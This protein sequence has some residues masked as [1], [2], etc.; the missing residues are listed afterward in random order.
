[1]RRAT[2]VVLGIGCLTCVDSAARA[3]APVIGG[4]DVPAGEWREVAAIEDNTN[5][6]FCTGTLIAPTVVLT[7]AHC[8]GTDVNKVV[9][10]TNSLARPQD[11]ETI[12]VKSATEYPG[13]IDTFDLGVVVLQTPSTITPRAIAAGWAS[14]AIKTG[15]TATVAGY[16][17]VDRDSMVFKD[18]M[19]EVD[20]PITDEDCTHSDG[21]NA[22]AKPAGELGAGGNGLDTCEGD[23][24]GPMFITGDLG[25]FLGGVTS[26][27]Y[28]SNQYTCSEGGIY[29]RPDK[30]IKWIED[31]AGVE[32]MKG[33]MPTWAD[34]HSPRGGAADTMVDANDPMSSKHTFEITA[35]P[36]YGMAAVHNDGSLRVCTS[37]DVTGKDSVTVTITDSSDPSR[38][39]LI[40]M[41]IVIEDAASPSSC[42][43]DDF[44]GDGGGCC[45]SSGHPAGSLALSLGV[46]AAIDRSSRRRRRRA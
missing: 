8:I 43:I 15:A 46:L 31:T 25:T 16:G 39:L 21:C 22:A 18:E 23:S 30:A 9:I 10:G 33:P 6:Q 35:Q 20:L 19:Q 38:K 11:G 24:G 37:P 3:E 40:V 13:G 1:M 36:M 17:G 44:G 41:P 27:G 45:S 7:A 42:N 28:D 26:R 5:F 14:L 32:V 12:M 2:A 29:V 4:H 34:L